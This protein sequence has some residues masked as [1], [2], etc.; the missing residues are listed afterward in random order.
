M[1]AGAGVTTF[2]NSIAS[3]GPQSPGGGFCPNIGNDL[4]YRW[5]ATQTGVTTLQTCGQ[6]AHDS[7][8][9]VYATSTCPT[10]GSSIACD[11]DACGLESLVSWNAISGGTY[12]LQI[13]SSGGGPGGPGTFTI[14]VVGVPANDDCATP[15]SI[16][17]QLG[18][19]YDNSVATDSPGGS[20]HAGCSPVTSDLWFEWIAPQNGTAVLDTCGQSAMDTAVLVFVGAGCPASAPIACDDNGCGSQSTVTW[21]IVAG[22]TYT[23]AVGRG[24]AAPGGPGSFTIVLSSGGSIGASF[25]SGDGTGTPCPCGNNGATG[26]GCGHSAGNSGFLQASGS[27]SV[28]NDSVLLSG[29]DMTANSSALYF[30]GTSQVNGGTGSVFGDGKRCAGGSIIRLGTKTNSGG[31]SSYPVGADQPVSIRGANVAGNVRTYQCWFRN[32]AAFCTV[33]TFNLTNGRQVTWAP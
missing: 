17:G 26:H 21:P 2:D 33:D 11:D 24:G 1:I 9:A 23:L 5:T 30:Q 10:A 3:A 15:I 25:C 12:M 8:I 14:S 22:V 20:G 4:W 32:A 6:V 27:A 16:T 29:S 31:A 18:A 28:S 7:A 13:G 19:A